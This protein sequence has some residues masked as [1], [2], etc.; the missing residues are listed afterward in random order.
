MANDKH[1]L[2]KKK[3][4]VSLEKLIKCAPPPILIPGTSYFISV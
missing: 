2:L 3:Y 4:V 1:F